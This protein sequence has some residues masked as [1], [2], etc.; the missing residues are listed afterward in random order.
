MGQW[1]YDNQVNNLA[2]MDDGWDGHKSKA[3]T[4]EALSVARSLSCCPLGTG[5]VQIELHAG[6]MDIEIEVEPD[7]RI[8][9][10]LTATTKPPTG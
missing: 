6:G 3:P 10:V 5:G 4:I 7:G 2:G 1:S 8:Y 9:C